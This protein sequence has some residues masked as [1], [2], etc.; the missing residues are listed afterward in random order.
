MAQHSVFEQICQCLAAKVAACHTLFDPV[1]VSY[2][3]CVFM[4]VWAVPQSFKVELH[5]FHKSNY[6]LLD[7]DHFFHYYYFAV[8][9]ER[10]QPEDAR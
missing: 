8:C 2:F 10:S 6:T 1:C 9:F 3:L 4:Y 5:Y 7:R